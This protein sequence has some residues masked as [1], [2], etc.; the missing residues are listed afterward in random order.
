MSLTCFSL[1]MSLMICWLWVTTGLLQHSP[2]STACPKTLCLSK[3]GASFLHLW[4]I[5]GSSFYVIFKTATSPCGFGCE[6]RS[7]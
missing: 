1:R 5:C 3:A 7:S 2:R 6:M 4:T